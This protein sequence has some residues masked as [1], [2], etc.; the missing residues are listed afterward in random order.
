MWYS[1]DSISYTIGL[2][3]IHRIKDKGSFKQKETGVIGHFYSFYRTRVSFDCRIVY[4]ILIDVNVSGH[5][6]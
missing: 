4:L 6:A 2:K 3:Q 5:L 1:I